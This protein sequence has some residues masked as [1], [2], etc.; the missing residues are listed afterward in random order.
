MAVIVEVRCRFLR[1]TNRLGAWF[2]KSLGL[3][4]NEA[5]RAKRFICR[6]VIGQKVRIATDKHNRSEPST[7]LRV[8]EMIRS[9]KCVL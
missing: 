6:S 5:F 2:S 4:A 1:A 3:P 9:K 8:T 7:Y